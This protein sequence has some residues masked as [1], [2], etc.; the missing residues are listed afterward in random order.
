MHRRRITWAIL[1]ATVVGLTGCAATPASPTVTVTS[2]VPG[3]TVT[4]TSTPR[5]ADPQAGDPMNALVAWTVCRTLG[6]AGY[7][8]DH[9]QSTVADYRPGTDSKPNGDG[10]FSATVGMTGDGG[11]VVSL[12][13][14]GGTLG[15]PTIMSWTMKDV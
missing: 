10:S 11:G 4:I 1:A 7:L 3:P 15:A 12:C 13:T 14:I 9:P 8:K 5:P 6:Y 2:P